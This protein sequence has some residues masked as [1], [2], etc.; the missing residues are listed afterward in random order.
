M[1]ITIAQLNP[2]IG[3]LA[4]NAQQILAAAHQAADQGVRLVLTPELSLCGYPPRDLLLRPG[5]IQAMGT[6]LTNLASQLPETVAVLVGFVEPNPTAGD[7]GGKPLFNSM[8][9][10]DEIGRASC[11]ERV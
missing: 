4:N 5:F 2:I 1:K 3:D 7:R 11:R 9:L 10:L 6:T 8:A